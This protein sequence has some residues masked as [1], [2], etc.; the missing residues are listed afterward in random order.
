MK[1]TIFGLACSAILVATVVI[2]AGISNT[3]TRTVNLQDNV[4][5]TLES[6][7]STTLEQKSYTIANQD[8]L[9]SDLTTTMASYLSDDS[10]LEIKIRTI[11]GNDGIISITATVK[12]AL[13]NTNETAKIP[14]TITCEKTVFLDKDDP[15][16][17]QNEEQA[18]TFTLTYQIPNGAEPPIL[19]K[20][21]EL[22]TPAKIKVPI[23]P[24]QT[25]STFQGW[26][27]LATGTIYSEADL[28]A[29]DLNKNY[30][31]LAVFQPL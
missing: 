16:Y 21:Y 5:E 15:M 3:K 14:D 27:D 23:A 6:S 26:K 4:K 19:Y 9:I 20:E 1:T 13:E 30:T 11:D 17:L 31:F 25:G 8:E 7:L 18:K 10:E 29:K 28:K 2:V 22:I 24:I 12:Y